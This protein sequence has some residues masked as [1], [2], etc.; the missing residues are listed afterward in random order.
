M[1]INKD[2]ADFQ[3]DTEDFS[4]IAPTD[5]LNDVTANIKQFSSKPHREIL[6]ALLSIV[7]KL[8]FRELADF[9]D[10]KETLK[11]KHFLI[12]AIE[13]ILELAKVNNWGLCKKHDFIYLYNSAFWSLL[14]DDDLKDFLGKAAEK[15]GID[16]FDCRHYQFK[17]QLYKQFLSASKLPEP[18]RKE[19]VVLINLLNT[20]P[21]QKHLFLKPI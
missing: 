9:E 8:D 13:Q 20:T 3:P 10:E 7:T 16:K 11:K 21:P 12:I 2:L 19:N 6:N 15:M 17:E 14:S 5:I 1:D 4:D 18:E